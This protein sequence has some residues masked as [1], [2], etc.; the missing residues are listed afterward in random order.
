MYYVGLTTALTLRVE[1]MQVMNTPRS[2][3]VRH[4]LAEFA[5]P[6]RDKS[7]AG[8]QIHWDRARGSD[9]RCVAQS[10]CLLDTPLETLAALPQANVWLK[11]TAEMPA[12]FRE[13][14]IK[15]YTLFVKLLDKKYSRAFSRPPKVAPIEIVI[16][17]LLIAALSPSHNLD[18][19]CDA[20]AQL[21]N[22]VRKEHVDIRSN[23]RVAKTMIDLVK[24]A[25]QRQKISDKKRKHPDDDDD[26]DDVPPNSKRRSIGNPVTP[27][28]RNPPSAPSL[29]NSR[30]L[31]KGTPVPRADARSR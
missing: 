3:F 27:S 14:V 13:Q 25:K 22:D 24:Q 28:S 19:L 17:P 20:I 18:Q 30:S 8:N 12:S 7:L 6:D 29:S 31:P 9:F 1:K 2:Q 15:V 10:L 16:I 4:I 21:R 5:D 23:G 11:S 26:D